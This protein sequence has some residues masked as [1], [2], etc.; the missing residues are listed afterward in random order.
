[1]SALVYSLTIS[2]SIRT[3]LAFCAHVS[4]RGYASCDPEL[5]LV[6]SKNLPFHGTTCSRH[7]VLRVLVRAVAF[8]VSRACE[9][10][11]ATMLAFLGVVF[12]ATG[13]SQHMGWSKGHLPTLH[14]QHGCTAN[15]LGCHKMI[16]SSQVRC[17]G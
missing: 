12:P 8:A 14:L 3:V 16:K 9:G 2:S 11:P 7:Y 10:K 5:I 15:Y 13:N 6:L 4:I 1:M 17:Q